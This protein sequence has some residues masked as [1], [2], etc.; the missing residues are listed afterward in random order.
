MYFYC[1]FHEEYGNLTFW[2]ENLPTL[3]DNIVV[4]ITRTIKRNSVGSCFWSWTYYK[5]LQILKLT[6]PFCYLS[7]STKTEQRHS[8]W[9]LLHVIHMLEFLNFCACG[10]QLCI[11]HSRILPCNVRWY[12][13]TYR[14]WLEPKCLCCFC[15]FGVTNQAVMNWFQKFCSTCNANWFLRHEYYEIY[16]L[17]FWW[18]TIVLMAQV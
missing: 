5:C 17:F 11:N 8:D 4:F 12:V 1:L 6:F 10:L 14:C 3:D 18:W 7:R 15:N 2:V 9:F 16:Y 13:I